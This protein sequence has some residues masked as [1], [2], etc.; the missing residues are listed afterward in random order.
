MHAK[1]A[2]LGASSQALLARLKGKSQLYWRIPDNA[3]DYFLIFLLLADITVCAFIT[4]L[5]GSPQFSFR[6]LVLTW[7]CK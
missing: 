4:V 2:R 5:L 3:V 7:S 1:K 6:P